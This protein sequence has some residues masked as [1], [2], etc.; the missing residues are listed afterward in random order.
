MTLNER[1]V[2]TKAL[3]KAAGMGLGIQDTVNL[4]ELYQDVISDMGDSPVNAIVAQ[5][6]IR[7]LSLG[8]R[9]ELSLATPVP[10]PP[11]VIPMPPPIPT[12]PMV[13]LSSTSAIASEN[14]A[15]D[16]TLQ[17]HYDELKSK[18]PDF[19]DVLGPGRS[20]P[21]RFKVE[22]Y[23]RDADGI[24]PASFGIVLSAAGDPSKVEGKFSY[25]LNK[26]YD[27]DKNIAEFRESIIN[28]YKNAGK[29]L[30]PVLPPVQLPSNGMGE[31][32]N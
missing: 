31:Q 16:R 6:E 9:E 7:P 12:R 22:V 32:W 11:P 30:T 20:V 28:M 8:Q 25:D 5:S 19:I 10:V 15:P 1:A 18:V 3:V 21:A 23:K 26:P 2:I 13:I 27:V 24:V 4:I 17:E 29:K 14:A